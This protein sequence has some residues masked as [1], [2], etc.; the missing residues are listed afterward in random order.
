MR[1][2]RA[3][4]FPDD[5]RELLQKARR[6]EWITIAV[7]AGVVAMMYAVMGSSQ[8]MKTAWT[9]DMLSLLPPLVYL[10][11]LRVA[12]KRP[13]ERFPYGY[14]RILTISFLCTSLAFTAF[15]G[16]LVF[17]S[18]S[19]L[20]RQER[21]TIGVVEIS[22]NLIWLGWLM[23]GALAISAI[24]PMWLG[25][26]KTK[27]ARQLHHKALHAEAGMNR[28]DWLTAIFGIAGILGIGFGF[29]WADA[30]AAI[31]IS[32]DVLFDGLRS[33]KN[34]L[35][36][37]ID[38]RPTH[39]DSS[40]PDPAVNEIRAKFAQLPWVREAAVRLREEGD[41][42]TGE[43]YLF[44]EDWRD[45][46]ERLEEAKKVAHEAHWRAYDITVVLDQQSPSADAR[47]AK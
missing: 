43:A 1:N 4:V 31:L 29:W 3:F 47:S 25:I 30:A 23:I 44:P 39:V 33:T 34:A 17:E 10:G 16:V 22:G 14:R 38:R 21:P 45:L 20:I 13:N 15:G 11:S 27:L 35:A 28:A 36:D 37:L 18:I 9:E 40:K 2:R 42:L 19:T 24:G 26:V 5:K 7:M 12:E 41:V 8:A 6:L 32:Q 46:P